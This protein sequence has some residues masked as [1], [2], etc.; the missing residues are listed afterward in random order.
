LA[1]LWPVVRAEPPLLPVDSL[2]AKLDCKAI[3]LGLAEVRPVPKDNP[4]TEEKAAL[5]RKLFFDPILSADR[6]VSCATCHQPAFGFAGSERVAS[7]IGGRKTTRNPPSLL[8]RAFGKSFFWDGRALS[9][10]EQALGPIANP[11]EMGTSVPAIVKRLAADKN[12]EQ[13]FRAVFPDGITEQNLARAIASFERTLLAGNSKIDRFR[14]GQ[15]DSLND[16]ERHGLWLYESRGGC[17]RCHSGPNFTDEEF[18]NTGVSWGKSDDTG[19]YA[20]TKKDVD[21]GRFKTP[22]LR[23]LTR[24]APFMHDGSLATLAEVI[25]FYNKG[26]TRNPNLDPVVAPLGLTEEEKR[27]LV[28]FLKA[29]ST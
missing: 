3:P 21:R 5:G 8:N 19:R 11:D 9:L 6:T 25:E 4:L 27:D 7:G 28:A 20:A 18:H 12:Y 2:P 1:G 15:I 13:Q 17:W 16:Q 22:S 24:T 23:G 14:A 10:E 29:L 26:G